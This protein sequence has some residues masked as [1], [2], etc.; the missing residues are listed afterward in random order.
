MAQKNKHFTLI[1][2]TTIGVFA[3]LVF[4]MNY[5]QIP[6]PLSV[7]GATRIH[8]G[9]MMC[10]LSGFVLGPVGGGLAA[11][12]GSELYDLFMGDFIYIP[13]YF[14]FKFMLAAVG[15]L[16]ANG[17]KKRSLNWMFCHAVGAVAGQL[18]YLVL[19]L[20]CSALFFDITLHKVPVETALINV[21]TRLGASSVNAVV[22]VVGATLLGSLLTK[23]FAQA[24]KK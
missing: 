20:S 10:L 24:Q 14:V 6:V 7:G 2:I 15:A 12:I 5:L 4:V 8:L 13:F 9:N 1:Q 17:L 23:I 11:G 16:V 18:T 3:A 19:H 21:T 22:A